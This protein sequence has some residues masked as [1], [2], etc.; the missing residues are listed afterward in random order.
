MGCGASKTAPAPDGEESNPFIS[1]EVKLDY[2]HAA[3]MDYCAL[4]GD[5]DQE[6]VGRL[7]FSMIERLWSDLREA[8][9]DGPKRAPSS[10]ADPSWRASGVG[11]G[12]GHTRCGLVP[13][14]RAA[15][16]EFDPEADPGDCGVTLWQFKVNFWRL[17]EPA[18][19][20]LP[21][22]RIP[23]VLIVCDPGPDPDDVK[24]VITAAKCHMT[25]ELD[26]RGI[27]CN[28]GHQA[29]ERARLA[30]CVLR[31]V[32]RTVCEKIPV[33]AGSAGQPYAPKDHEYSIAG[34][35]AD[36]EAGAICEGAAL[37][38]RVLRQAA[39]RSLIVQI[40]S[41]F[42]DVAELIDS[43]PELFQERSI[44]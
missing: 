12:D 11:S 14:P 10:R 3:A 1:R 29:A 19:R 27:V 40:Q 15:M 41:G 38:S 35:D 30:R 18:A 22:V 16:Q 5:Y 2:A 36:D 20:K 26:V 28:G 6:S 33:A 4:F 9:I 42:T 17:L 7:S 23:P 32:D 43:E 44:A 21:R 34:F 37:C 39:P 13:G 24:V 25:H 8:L 31:L